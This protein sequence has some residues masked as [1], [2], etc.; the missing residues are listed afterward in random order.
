MDVKPKATVADQLRILAEARQKQNKEDLK[1]IVTEA[2]R[3]ANEGKVELT[4]YQYMTKWVWN[5]LVDMGFDLEET[6][7]DDTAK[8]REVQIKW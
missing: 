8:T 3:L 7:H 2:T 6:M 4:W 1:N 5:Q